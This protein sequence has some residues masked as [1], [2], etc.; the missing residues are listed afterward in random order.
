MPSFNGNSEE[1]PDGYRK[2][3]YQVKVKVP[4]K[5]N[6]PVE[7][8]PQSMDQLCDAIERVLRARVS[9]NRH[10]KQLVVS[11]NNQEDLRNLHKRILSNTDKRKTSTMRSGGFPTIEQAPQNLDRLCDE[12]SR[13]IGARVSLQRRWGTIKLVIHFTDERHLRTIRDRLINA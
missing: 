13:A 6:F 11:L 4:L 7:Q 1:C 3:V 9:L 8:A 2:Y 12:I 5:E 10:R